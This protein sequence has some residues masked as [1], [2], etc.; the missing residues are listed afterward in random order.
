MDSAK[1]SL[2]IQILENCR[3]AL[4]C[5]FPNFDGAFA[6]L[7]YRPDDAVSGVETEGDAL[8]FS[9]D[10]LISKFRDC[11]ASVRRGYLHVLLHCLYLHPFW[12]PPEQLQ[13]WDLACDL[14]VEQMI[15]RENRPELALPQN[16]VRDMCFQLMGQR[17]LSAQT[18]D[19]WLEEGRFPFSLEEM[20]GAFSFDSH[21]RWFG[22]SNAAVSSG[23][24]R[25]WEELLAYTNHGQTGSRP[26]TQAGSGKEAVSPAVGPGYDYRRFL[27]QF[28]VPREEVELDTESFDYIFYHFG[29]EHYGDL[30]LIE[31]LEYKEV[32]RLEELVIAIDTSGSCSKETVQQFLTETYRILSQRENFFQKMKVYLIQCDCMVQSVSVIHNQEEWYRQAKEIVIQGRGGTDFT[33]VFRL[34]EQLRKEKALRGPRALIYFTDGDGFYPREKP[35]FETAFV[36]LQKSERLNLVPSWAR[37]LIVHE[38]GGQEP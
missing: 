13:R 22:R 18:L 8:S 27:K 1:A 33:P 16:P 35:A 9:P 15:Q 23:G 14:A 5:M 37:T 19:R 7:S 36:F 24:R 21:T 30:P 3:N 34:I 4:Y 6:A 38:K 12:R 28:A 31:P 17:A 2:G 26:G 32:C 25:K 11:P 20:A 10:Y 29:M